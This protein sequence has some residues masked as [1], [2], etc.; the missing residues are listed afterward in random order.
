MEVPPPMPRG[1]RGASKQAGIVSSLATT[2]IVQCPASATARLTPD[3]IR[4]A[5]LKLYAG[6]ELSEH[7]AHMINDLFRGASS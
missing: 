6:E 2:T 5:I 1:G 7:E 3:D 4:A